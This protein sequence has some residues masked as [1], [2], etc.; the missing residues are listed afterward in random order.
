MV[1]RENFF[2]ETILPKS[3]I[4][5]L[6]DEEMNVYRAPFQTKE[7]RLPTLV[8]PREL[9][10]GGEPED[11]TSIVEGYGAWLAKSSIPKLFISAEPGALMTARA[12][13][14]CRTWPN[15]HEVAVKGIHYTQ[16]D[17]PDEI[18]HALAQFVQSVQDPS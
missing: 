9:P 1:L 12:R 10:I 11:V 2:I 14:F 13:E 3:V 7:A 15:Q 17:S 5:R 4:R 6:S 16:D 18:G 8:W